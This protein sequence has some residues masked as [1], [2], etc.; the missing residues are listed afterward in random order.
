MTRLVTCLLVALLVSACA[1]APS[2]EDG[3]ARP[4]ATPAPGPIL[5]G[6]VS[7]EPAPLP[8]P[9][10]ASAGKAAVGGD[11]DNLRA[12]EGVAVG[13]T[14]MSSHKSRE[15]PTVGASAPS[16]HAHGPL[17]RV[18]GEPQ[19]YGMYTYVLFGRKVGLRE[20]P[21]PAAVLQRYESLLK[22]LEGRVRSAAT[23]DAAGVAR[24]R[25]NLFCIPAVTEN[26]LA[27]LENYNS[28]IASIYL[29][30]AGQATLQDPRLHD[31]L[32]AGDGPFLVSSLKP[33]TAGAGGPL[34]V[35]DLGDTA[36]AAMEEVVMEYRRQLSAKPLASVED[37]KS[38]RLKLLNL[39]LLTD[40]NIRI[41]K[42]ALA[43]M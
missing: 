43:G 35:A 22:A 10:P 26:K 32:G 23:L 41:V 3:A 12:V 6:G 8:A 20:P 40:T 19:G 25:V 5:K 28:E 11:A 34:M 1:Q 33:L 2:R 18:G 30:W 29:I 27:A 42:E 14:F 36:P 37:F 15:M 31:K 17:L 21:P 4:Q 9:A 7:P 38:L 16:E 39:I 24:S 13:G